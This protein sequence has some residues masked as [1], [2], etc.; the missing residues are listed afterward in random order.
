[1]AD[2]LNTVHRNFPDY[3]LHDEGHALRVIYMMNR[4]LNKESLQ[5]LTTIDIALLILSAYAHDLG[6][7]AGRE[8]RT[9][10][11]KSDEFKDFLLKHGD[12]WVEAEKHKDEGDV[13]KSEHIYS[14]LFQTY[15][16][17]KHHLISEEV[18]KDI[19][20]DD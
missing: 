5:S 13:K 6:M 9:R 14:Q 7:A 19:Y 2:A 4:L 16:R 8:D 20:Y 3:T 11:E 12:F 15:L 18:I 1:M 10:I 17:E